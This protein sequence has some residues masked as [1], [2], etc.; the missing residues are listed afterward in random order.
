MQKLN[1]SAE[2]CF[3]EGMPCPMEG[4][5]GILVNAEVVDCSCHI[6]PPCGACVDAGYECPEC[7]WESNPK[8]ESDKWEDI[9]KKA[10]RS[11]QITR[12]EVCSPLNS[13]PFTKCCGTAAI[14]EDRCPSCNA[15]ISNRYNVDDPWLAARRAE[16]AAMPH[17]GYRRCLLCSKPVGPTLGN[18]YCCC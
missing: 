9:P 13:T 12:V 14:N 7:H 8:H 4:C 1:I 18:G 6:N 15:T 11:D 2:E 5:T 3:E 16:L 10:D 17:T